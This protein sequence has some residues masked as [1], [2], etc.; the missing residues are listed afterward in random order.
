LHPKGIPMVL[1]QELWAQYRYWNPRTW[2]IS[3]FDGDQRRW[4]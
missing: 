3:S 2:Y 1:R 4:D